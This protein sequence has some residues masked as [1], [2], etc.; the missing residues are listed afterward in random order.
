MSGIRALTYRVLENRLYQSWLL[1]GLS[2]LLSAIFAFAI[3]PHLVGPFNVHYMRADGYYDL[4]ESLLSG[5]GFV[6][7][8]EPRFN[9]GAF[10]REPMY[11][12]FLA[13]FL[14][15]PAFPLS[16]I[17]AQIALFVSTTLLSYQLFLQYGKNERLAFWTAALFAVFPFSF[18]YVAKPTPENISP[19]FLLINAWL[20]QKYVLRPGHVRAALWGMSLTF[21]V[22]VKSN[23]VVLVPIG[24]AII[25]IYGARRAAVLSHVVLAILVF[26]VGMSP[27]V[28]RNYELSG[29]FIWGS[30]M[31]GT[32]FFVGNRNADWETIQNLATNL[33]GENAIYSEWKAE[34]HQKKMI[35]ANPDPYRLEAEIDAAFD[36]RVKQWISA[37]KQSFAQKLVIN[38]STLWF[39]TSDRAKSLV[40]LVFQG[41]L[42]LCAIFGILASVRRGLNP[43]EAYMLLVI[44]TLYIAHSAILADARYTHVFLPFTIYFAVTA[45]ATQIRNAKKISQ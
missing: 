45:V 40:L 23:L 22:Y 9:A 14:S 27:W 12:L 5:R 15:L 8:D 30:S 2:A 21:A 35:A 18:W 32:S 13:L 16:M 36:A 3:F 4:A 20:L 7:G 37:N 42:F 43:L 41:P 11:P 26:A 25:M 34:Y 10:K 33:K 17:L 44:G 6:F 38:A 24:I 28:E 19:L 39:I 29:R 1:V 31:G